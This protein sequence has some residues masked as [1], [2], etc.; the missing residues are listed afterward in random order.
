MLH[1]AV[2][3]HLRSRCQHTL[4]MYVKRLTLVV[5]AEWRLYGHSERS[6]RGRHVRSKPPAF[7]GLGQIGCFRNTPRARREQNFGSCRKLVHLLLLPLLAA[8][9]AIQ[10]STLPTHPP[11][12]PVLYLPWLTSLRLASSGMLGESHRICFSQSHVGN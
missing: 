7:L 5:R 3:G 8:G 1:G 11:L 4:N 10:L 9:Q 12:I 2:Q 6:R